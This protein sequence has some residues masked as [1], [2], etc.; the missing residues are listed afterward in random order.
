MPSAAQAI[1]LSQYDAGAT[2]SERLIVALDVPDLDQA[3][4][5]VNELDQAVSYYKVGPHLFVRGLID[6]IEELIQKRGK[7]IFLDFKSFDIG[8]TIRGMA[9]QAARLKVDFMTIGRT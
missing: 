6:F 1:P 8:D 9:S 3:W 4:E 7:K 5:I 2:A